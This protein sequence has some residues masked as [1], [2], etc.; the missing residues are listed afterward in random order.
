M[1]QHLPAD[2]AVA[3]SINDG[4][5]LT[6]YMI[7]DLIDS[8][9][10]GRWEYAKSNGSESPQPDPIPRPGQDNEAAKQGDQM[11]AAHDRIMGRLKGGQG[12]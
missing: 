9:R 7:A 3:R 8:S 6:H 5:D 11:R 12:G 1:V 2:S 4:W 10:M